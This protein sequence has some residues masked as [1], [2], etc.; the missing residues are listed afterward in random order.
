[1]FNQFATKIRHNILFASSK[2]SL[3]KILHDWTTSAA[4]EVI[5]GHC[6][7]FSYTLVNLGIHIQPYQP[8]PLEGQCVFINISRVMNSTTYV[9][10]IVNFGNNNK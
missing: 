9:T 7:N 2:E 1:M 4:P 3:P 8:N 6:R 10:N 5:P